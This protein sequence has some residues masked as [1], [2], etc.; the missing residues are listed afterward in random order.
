MG[1]NPSILLA[2]INTGHSLYDAYTQWRGW[3]PD[4]YYWSNYYN[5]NKA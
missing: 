3:F 1:A 4:C 2:K 5:S